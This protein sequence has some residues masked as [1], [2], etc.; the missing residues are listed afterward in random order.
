MNAGRIERS[1][2][3]AAVLFLIALTAAF[4]AVLTPSAFAH[5]ER[6]ES[7]PAPRSESDAVPTEVSISFTEPPTSDSKVSVLDGCGDEVVED[8]VSAGTE[9]TISLREG[10]PG[11]WKVETT[12]ISGLDGHPKSDSWGFRV[13]GQADCSAD[14]DPA[15]SEDAAG[16]GREN[17]TE[18]GGGF[19]VLVLVGGAA[20]IGIAVL[21]RVL[22]GGKD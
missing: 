19:P 17:E 1:R 21:V 4:S 20:V 14:P 6:T 8:V 16:P 12:V 15:P 7:R 22:L 3:L 9:M 10:Q 2:L 11:R 5:A 13:A 18:D